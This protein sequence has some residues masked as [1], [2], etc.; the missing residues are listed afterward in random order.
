[1]DVLFCVRSFL[2]RWRFLKSIHNSLYSASIFSISECS[3]YPLIGSVP[4]Q[5][6]ALKYWSSCVADQLELTLVFIG[7]MQASDGCAFT[8]I[9]G[10]R[11]FDGDKYNKT[12]RGCLKGGWETTFQVVTAR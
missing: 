2:K 11:F 1:M 6:G 8:I 10:Y 7:L 12:I 3:G 9:F 4:G 5:T